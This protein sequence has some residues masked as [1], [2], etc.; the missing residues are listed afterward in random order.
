MKKSIVLSQCNISLITLMFLFISHLTIAQDS[1]ITTWKTDN[2]GA[3]ASNMIRIPTT[4]GGYNYDVDWGDG[5][6]TTGHSGK[7]CAMV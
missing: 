4:G 5:N 7:I 2:P 1:F 6:T 3:T